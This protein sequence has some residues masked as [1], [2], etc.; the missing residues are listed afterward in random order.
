MAGDVKYDAGD[1]FAQVSMDIAGAYPA[2]A[3]LKRWIRTVRLNRGRNVEVGDLF[4]FK[5]TGGK[6]TENL[7]T[8]CEVFGKK[9]GQIVL[10]DGEKGTKVLLEYDTD[11]LEVKVEKIDLSDE[12]LAEVWGERLYRIRLIGK[13]AVIRDGLKFRFSIVKR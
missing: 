5:S 10:R 4:E 3:D 13:N 8:P 11:K 9:S 1:D 2:A 6:I 7:I 12:R